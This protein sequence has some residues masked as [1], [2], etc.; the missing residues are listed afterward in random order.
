MK[1]SK[2]NATNYRTKNP[3]A[4]AI[5]SAAP[6]DLSAKKHQR[7]VWFILYPDSPHSTGM[8]LELE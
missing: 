1:R 7:A 4:K 2:A 3:L 8:T 5:L 6:F